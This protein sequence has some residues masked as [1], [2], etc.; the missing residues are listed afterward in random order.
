MDKSNDKTKSVR[1]IRDIR[2]F[3]PESYRLPQDGRKWKVLCKERRAIANHI[4]TYANGDGTSIKAGVKRW[5]KEIGVSRATIFRR[6]DDLRK[7]GVLRDKQ[8]LTGEN[9]TALRSL[10]VSRLK[11]PGEAGAE[12]SGSQ[13]KSQIH[14]A[15][16]VSDSTSEVSG[17]RPE[18]SGSQSRSL[19]IAETQPSL[20]PSTN[21]PSNRPQNL[22]G[23]LAGIHKDAGK[24]QLSR[25]G[26]KDV[27]TLPEKYG[28]DED[29]VERVYRH[30]LGDRNIEGLKHPLIKFAEEFPE[31][32]DAVRVQEKRSANQ[33]ENTRKIAESEAA[34]AEW[35]KQL[36][37]LTELPSINGRD[38]GSDEWVREVNTWLEANPK[39]A[40]L[41]E[42][43]DGGLTSIEYADSIIEMRILLGRRH[44][45]DVLAA[46]HANEI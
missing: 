23:R 29:T 38:R 7:L 33:V 11:M 12:V 17:S 22:M 39:P 5:V 46:A 45:E 28:V 15:P 19:T 30:W 14:G 24:G 16:E 31:S 6:L 35:R 4:A 8:G 18:V 44:A 43:D 40:W 1:C 21:R 32:L 41:V 20:L 27:Q 37:R 42:R 34:L 9:G 3:P 36:E 2:E 10:D 26:L 13:E 25:G